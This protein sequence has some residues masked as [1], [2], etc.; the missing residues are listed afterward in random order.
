MH[1]YNLEVEI[2]GK[3]LSTTLSE[4]GF[5]LITGGRI[6]FTKSFLGFALKDI[7]LLTFLDLCNKS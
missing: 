6:F 1:N 2:G 4:M 5:G 3:K 7:S